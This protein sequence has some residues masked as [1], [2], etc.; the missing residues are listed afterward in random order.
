M[1]AKESA[2]EVVVIIGTAVELKEILISKMMFK[3]CK[4]I[5]KERQIN[6]FDIRIVL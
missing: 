3:S 4:F 2:T 6:W 5:S 1:Y